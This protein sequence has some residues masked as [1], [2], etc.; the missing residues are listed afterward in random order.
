MNCPKCRKAIPDESKFCPK[1]G[2]YISGNHL[3]S[4]EVLASRAVKKF[5]FGAFSFGWIYFAAANARK[6]AIIIL[7]I[8]V[9][10]VL[11]DFYSQTRSLPLALT[12]SFLSICFCLY[13]GSIGRIVSANSRPWKD[14]AEF[15]KNQLG[16]D[17]FGIAFLG[18]SILAGWLIANHQNELQQILGVR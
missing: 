5:S 15:R 18:L 7:L 10:L 13:L 4:D 9:P 16:W 17:L 8:S 1:C 3:K 6:Q 11:A 14:F 12:G 2:K